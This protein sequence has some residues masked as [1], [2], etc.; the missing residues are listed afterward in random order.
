MSVFALNFFLF[1]FSILIDIDLQVENTLPGSQPRLINAAEYVQLFT[2]DT[3]SLF[4][5]DY[6]QN[7]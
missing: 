5:I 1:T 7:F 2:N 6:K 3:I 4:L